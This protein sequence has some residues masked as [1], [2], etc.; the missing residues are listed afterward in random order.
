MGSDTSTAVVRCSLL[1]LGAALLVFSGVA[2]CGGDDDPVG[3]GRDVHAF[4][5]ESG[6]GNWEPDAT[7]LDDPPISW[8]IDTTTRFADDGDRAVRLRLENLNDAGKIWIERRFDVE[9][10]TEYDI[11]LTFA[12]GTGDGGSINLWTVIAGA[13]G[14][15]PETRTD[16]TFQ[17]DTGHEQGLGSG[18]VWVD[19]SYGLTARSD[20]DGSLWVS[21]GVWGTYEVT[22]IYY[23]DDVQIRLE[24]RS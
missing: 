5:F 22:R 1:H 9:P 24:P 6:L 18:I 16:L 12:F 14:H 23:V 13:H 17:G 19:R 2:A 8:E 11:D 20:A 4:S 7:D 21:I 3:P 10:E 15:D